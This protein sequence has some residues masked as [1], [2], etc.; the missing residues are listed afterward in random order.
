MI[1]IVRMT[2]ILSIFL[3]FLS[4]QLGKK[5]IFNHIYA[6][7][8]PVTRPSQRAIENLIKKTLEGTKR[9]S[10]KIF[11][12][13]VPKFKDTVNSKLSSSNSPVEYV[14]KI[15]EEDKFKLD[16]LIREQN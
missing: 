6:K 13:S 16:E 4:I 15:T 10:V 1:N 14:E 11:D 5:T 2:G 12:N 7:I 3:I 8:S 9:Y